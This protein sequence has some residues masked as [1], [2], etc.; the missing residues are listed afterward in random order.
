MLTFEVSCLMF[1]NRL[2]VIKQHGNSNEHDQH[3]GSCYAV[4]S[5]ELD[6]VA[7]LSGQRS[8]S[9]G[10]ADGAIGALELLVAGTT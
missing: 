4:L 9:M 2:A 10:H 7:S 3:C 5:S 1:C 6:F 8:K